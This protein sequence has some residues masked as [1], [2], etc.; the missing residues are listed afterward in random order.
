MKSLVNLCITAQTEIRCIRENL[1]SV[2]ENWWFQRMGNW[3]PAFQGNMK[4]SNCTNGEGDSEKWEPR[5][6][7]VFLTLSKT[8]ER[9]KL[10]F[11][12]EQYNDEAPPGHELLHVLHIHAPLLCVKS[13]WAG[14]GTS[15][16][17]KFLFL[18]PTF[19]LH[20]VLWD[21]LCATPPGSLKK[22][23]ASWLGNVVYYCVGYCGICY[24]RL[25]WSS[26]ACR[27][28][29]G[30]DSSTHYRVILHYLQCVFLFNNLL[31]YRYNYIHMRCSLVW[32]NL[33]L[34]LF[35]HPA[36]SLLYPLSCLGQ[37]WLEDFW[38]TTA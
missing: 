29:P 14:W 28:L 15:R 25:S 24:S 11:Q 10:Q 4:T 26:E 1:E 19:Y 8:K 22:K 5:N 2:P 16:V 23:S 31:Q 7:L 21:G 18:N 30:W 33:S 34:G 13:Q 12:L 3:I 27:L 9:C 36:V 17:R 38:L 37:I 6:I 20:I 35:L 32:L